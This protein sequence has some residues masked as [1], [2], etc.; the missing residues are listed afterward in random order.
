MTRRVRTVPTDLKVATGY[1]K[2]CECGAVDRWM[3]ST[4]GDGSSVQICKKCGKVYTV[5][6]HYQ[7]YAVGV[8]LIAFSHLSAI[9]TRKPDERSA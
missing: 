9:V 8:R 4:N 1:R 5:G 7:D 6:R 2:N 3:Y